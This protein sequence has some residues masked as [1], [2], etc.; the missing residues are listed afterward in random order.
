MEQLVGLVG[1]RLAQALLVAG[2]HVGVLVAKAR[3]AL[4][5]KCVERL[6]AVAREFAGLVDGLPASASASARARHDLDEVV[7][8]LAR[9]DGGE[10]LLGVCQATGHG[11]A[12]F[13]T[14]QVEG[15][16][17]PTVQAAHLD[18]G[19]G[20]GVGAV[21]EEVRAAQRGLH[22]A[23]GRAKDDGGAGTLVH[24]VVKG[25]LVE[26]GD[27]DVHEPY[28]PA[29]F[30]YGEHR[31]DVG[32]GLAH[33][34]LDGGLV[35]LGHAWHAGHVED[36]LAH[37]TRRGSA[38]LAGCRHGCVVIGAGADGVGAHA[39]TQSRALAHARKLVG[40]LPGRHH[41]ELETD[42]FLEQRAE[43]LLRRFGAREMGE[44]VGV[45]DLEVAHPAW[46]A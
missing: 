2:R 33:H 46:A 28:E 40:A 23:S 34:L 29:E 17:L 16:L 15:L 5:V 25:R 45:L 20:I 32:F 9:F 36:A 11:D 42:V 39:N 27:V 24:R 41:A 6:A 31:I 7:F 13:V 1:K 21:D 12:H 19:I 44:L 14:T 10:Q 30:A 43:H 26:R 4:A 8:D 3:R 37:R 18:E 22:D 38:R 35:L